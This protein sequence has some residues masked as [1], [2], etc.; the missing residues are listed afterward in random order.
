[1]ADIDNNN[2]SST[3]SAAFENLAGSINSLIDINQGGFGDLIGATN[4]MSKSQDK[5]LTHIKKQEDKA[6]EEA[7]EGIKDVPMGG[8]GAA[9]GAAND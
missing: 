8:Q 2:N 7:R 4:D 9:K 3:V 6:Y 1:M 5:L